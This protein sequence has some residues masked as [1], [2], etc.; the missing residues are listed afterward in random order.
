MRVLVDE[1]QVAGEY[2]QSW[3]GRDREGA[4]V[5]PGVYF[6]KLEVA[7]GAATKTIVLVE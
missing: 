6:A 2:M 1:R 7:G 3:D 5:P 4:G